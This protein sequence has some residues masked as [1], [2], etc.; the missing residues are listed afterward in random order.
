LLE[1]FFKPLIGSKDIVIKY[2]NNVRGR[3]VFAKRD[4][5]KGIEIL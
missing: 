3:G 5:I 4:F 2:I 1:N